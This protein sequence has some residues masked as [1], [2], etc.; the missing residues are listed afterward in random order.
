MN[1]NRKWW[2]TWNSILQDPKFQNVRLED[3]GFWTLLMSLVC[4][5]G[6]RGKLTI[7]PPA[8]IT[9]ALLRCGNVENMKTMLKRLPNVTI[10]PLK[11][12]NGDFIVTV[13]KWFTYQVDPTA[14][15]RVKRSRYKR[16]EEKRREEETP[17][18]SERQDPKWT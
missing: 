2:K 7:I 15:D 9:V 16:R 13:S 8:S 14:S 6:E 5:Q 17:F 12:D 3:I 18:L 11:S 10:D 1:D 4:E